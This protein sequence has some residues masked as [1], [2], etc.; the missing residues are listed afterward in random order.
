MA[1]TVISLHLQ[2][3]V[4]YPFAKAINSLLGGLFLSTIIP[5]YSFLWVK[6][7]AIYSAII[8]MAL[9]TMK[10]PCEGGRQSDSAVL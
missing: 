8:I 1:S 10:L 5:N 7:L 2:C 9:V 3:L 6:G 4:L